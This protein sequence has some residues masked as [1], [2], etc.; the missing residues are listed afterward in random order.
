LTAVGGAGP[1]ACPRKP[2][3]ICYGVLKNRQP[4]GPAWS[5]KMTG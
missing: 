3:M 1:G 5:S 2:M 4:F